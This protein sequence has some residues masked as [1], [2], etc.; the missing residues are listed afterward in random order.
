MLIV[1]LAL[2]LLAQDAPPPSREP[3]HFHSLPA[4]VV[5]DVDVP[6]GAIGTLQAR[7]RCD[8]TEPDRLGTCQVLREG[9]FGSR[10]GRHNRR[11]LSGQRLPPG[12]VIPG[13]TVEFDVWVC[14]G[15]QRPCRMEPWPRT[16]ERR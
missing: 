6:Q 10:F 14:P 13:D 15:A 16:D 9:P 8:V 12:S 1:A 11:R 5:P 7:F 2:T 3:R 4:G